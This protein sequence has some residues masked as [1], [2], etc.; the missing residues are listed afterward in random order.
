MIRKS[1]FHVPP[2]GLLRLE[3]VRSCDLACLLLP[4]SLLRKHDNNGLQIR[5]PVGGFSGSKTTLSLSLIVIS[6]FVQPMPGNW[7]DIIRAVW[8]CIVKK[9]CSDLSE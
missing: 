8:V 1:G 9:T 7:Q 3:V 6:S 5:L 4:T 2:H